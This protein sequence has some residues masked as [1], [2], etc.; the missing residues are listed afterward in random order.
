VKEY[1]VTFAESNSRADKIIKNL[2]EDIGYV[3]LQ[4]LFR[5]GKI[6]VNEKKAKASDRLYVGDVL[7][8]Y[9]NFSTK[10]EKRY[11]FDRRL[12]NQF[13]NIIIF[14]NDDFLAI[15]KPNNIA[16]QLGTNISIC[17]ETLMRAYQNYTNCEYKLVHR[18]DKD[19]SG[20]LLIAKNLAAARKLTAMFKN[21]E[22]KKTY[23]AVVNGKVNRRG[24]IDNFIKKILVGGE[25]KMKIADGGKRATTEYFPLRMLDPE[26]RFIN[27]T[28]LKLIP[29]TGRKH[30]LR[31]HCAEVLKSAIL[32]DRKYGEDTIHNKLFLHA[33]KVTVDDIEIVAQIPG[34]FPNIENVDEI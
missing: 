8:I 25:E 18:L 6:K 28:L 7:H 3:Y 27:C 17:I 22:I 14:E 13:K 24:I 21:N 20:V 4:K 16:V 1:I 12:A 15:N 23:L 10:N 31:L 26:E 2:Y 19:T 9:D 29:F 11:F 5:I 32:G 33:H 30:Q 34:Y